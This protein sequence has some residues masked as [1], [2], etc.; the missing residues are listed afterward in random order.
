MKHHEKIIPGVKPVLTPY[1]GWKLFVGFSG[2][3]DSCAL[4][5]ALQKVAPELHISLEAIHFEH[6]IRGAAS[7]R[8]AA[9]CVAFC[10]VRNIPCRVIPLAT[11][12]NRLP[13]E[14][15]EAA[16]R[17][18]RLAQW[19]HLITAT[20]QAVVLGHH[21]DDVTEN[22]LLRL[23]RGGNSGSLSALRQCREINDI[24]FLRPLLKFTRLE[25]RGFLH[26]NHLDSWCED[27]TN[28]DTSNARNYLRREVLPQL[29]AKF[30][31]AVPGIN[32]AADALECD[33]DYIELAA[34]EAFREVRVKKTTSV[35]YWKKLHPALRQRV[36]KL[37]LSAR[38][39]R[40]YVPDSHMMQRFNQMLE[41]NPGEARKIPIIGGGEMLIQHDSVSISSKIAPPEA[42]C[43]AWR[44]DS[45]II[46]GLYTL[47]ADV[48]S[49]LPSEITPNE[50]YID[51]DLLPDTLD[52][53]PRQDGD[54]IMPF[55]RKT[56]VKLKKIFTDSGISSNE[57]HLRPLLCLPDG[58]I[59]WVPGIRQTNFA[60]V[61][62]VTKKII[63]F[64]LH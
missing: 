4:L 30:S 37:W 41:A 29:D 60:P 48:V 28:E 1:S 17:R 21:A 64:S 57:S 43:W 51:A 12:E 38:L 35:E 58:I 27:T 47:Q 19:G 23:F 42:I 61:T 2:G 8:D 55:G 15:L 14:N 59:I 7:C 3:A 56:E 9:W 36:L 53:R 39:N 6:G 44:K 16:A 25:L 31:F 34:D 24:L 11:P 52:I 5:L 22:V 46:F 33:A 54:R 13:G 63:R 40:F 18:L 45:S 20:D 26:E 32:A 62:S 10:K 49:S 50:A